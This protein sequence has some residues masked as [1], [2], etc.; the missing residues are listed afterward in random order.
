M[1]I[2]KDNLSV[3]GLSGQG[4]SLSSETPDNIRIT[5]KNKRKKTEN[6]LIIIKQPIQWPFNPRK[7]SKKYLNWCRKISPKEAPPTFRHKVDY[8]GD[9][10]EKTHGSDYSP[11]ETEV[12][13]RNLAKEHGNEEDEEFKEDNYEINDTNESKLSK[14][15]TEEALI[16]SLIVKNVSLKLIQAVIFY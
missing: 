10:N 11:S 14:N 9:T 6:T 12:C 3:S 13:K 8:K 4:K 16:S 5:L 2:H 1:N 15:K 7:N